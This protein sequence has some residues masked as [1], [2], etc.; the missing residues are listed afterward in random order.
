D[1]VIF[2]QRGEDDY[3]QPFK[4]KPN[5]KRWGQ[6]VRHLAKQVREGGYKLVIIDPLVDFWPVQDENSAGEQTA[7][8]LPLRQITEAGASVLLL[9]HPRK[10]GGDEGRAARGS[11]QLSAFADVLIELKRVDPKEH[12]NCCRKLTTLGRYD[13]LVP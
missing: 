11:G 2:F 10:S 5:L 1:E 12:S 9:H 8:L 13:G 6:L 4:G 3:P 7:A